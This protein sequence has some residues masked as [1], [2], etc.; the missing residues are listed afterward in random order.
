LTRPQPEPD[1]Q[2][3]IEAARNDPSRFAELYERNFERV[4][5]YVARRIRNRSEAEDVT[6]DVFHRALANM[7]R[8]EWRGAPFSAWLFRI[9]AN[10]L[11]DRS[12]RA[13]RESDLPVPD[14]E[15]PD[16]EED[17]VEAV[18]DRVRLA[19]CLRD[20]PPDQRRVVVMRFLSEKRIRV[21]AGEMAR[22]E[23]AVKQLQFRALENLRDCMGRPNV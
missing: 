18:E 21:I 22:S 14:I 5:A 11:A 15:N 17:D 20:L 16:I 1:E 9:A 23:G 13:A 2:L 10:A 12:Q 4:Y 6:S 7:G 19:R 3:L 8:F